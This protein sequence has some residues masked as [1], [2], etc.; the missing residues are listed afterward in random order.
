MSFTIDRRS[1][2]GAAASV[3]PTSRA[4]AATST[5][6]VRNYDALT[7]E[8]LGASNHVVRIATQPEGEW[9]GMG[10]SSYQ[11]GDEGYRWQIGWWLQPLAITQ[12]RLPAYREL[13][14]RSFEGF[15]AKMAHRD[16]WSYWEAESMGVATRDTLGVPGRDKP[17]ADPI[18][19]DNINYS[20]NT[21]NLMAMHQMLYR[22]GKYLQPNSFALKHWTKD[23]LEVFGYDLPKIAQ[24]LYDGFAETQWRGVA[25][26][27][28][29]VYPAYCNQLA[30]VAFKQYDQLLSGDMGARL[31]ANHVRAWQEHSDL[32]RVGTHVPGGREP[33]IPR[34]YYVK[35][36]AMVAMGDTMMSSAAYVNAWNAAWVEEN[37]PYWKKRFTVTD[38]V[39]S[40]KLEPEVRG[41]H[42]HHNPYSPAANQ[43]DNWQSPG[44]PEKGETPPFYFYAAISAAE[45]GDGELLGNIRGHAA[46][47]NNQ[48]TW[49][50]SE[51]FYDRNERTGPARMSRGGAVLMTA[52]HLVEKDSFR[53]LYNLPLTEAD[54]HTPQIEG[55]DWPNIL[56]RRAVFDKQ[57]QALVV[58][59]LSAASLRDSKAAAVDTRFAIANL[60]PR[61][62]YAISCDGAAIGRVRGNTVLDGADR[63]QFA[64]GKLIVGTRLGTDRSFIAQAV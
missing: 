12:Y 55:V 46:K 16:S 6:D 36:G 56:V 8:Q 37:Y 3:I 38:G 5:L 15:L 10:I 41:G 25:C 4:L 50:G 47:F 13:Y 49:K 45:M 1:F 20:A 9:Y 21:M 28:N 59:L 57:R 32:Y 22:D 17:T 35:Q 44:T 33:F 26:E 31:I 39:M 51:F 11:G 24:V 23:G 18:A 27:V 62:T 40:V 48:A 61:K 29:G 53:K 43:A 64:D 2:L 58:T 30:L 19:R 63:L 34:A 52:A 60:D 54:V 14:K 7:D 42:L